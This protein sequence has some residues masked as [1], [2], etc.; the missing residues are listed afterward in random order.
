MEIAEKSDAFEE[1]LLSKALY[2][3][4]IFLTQEKKE[5][6]SE[7]GFVNIFRIKLGNRCFEGTMNEEAENTVRKYYNFCK[8]FILYDFPISNI[9]N[10]VI[11]ASLIMIRDTI[12]RLKM[13]MISFIDKKMRNLFKKLEISLDNVYFASAQKFRS[14][15]NQLMPMLYNEFEEENY[16]NK[17][18]AEI[19]LNMLEKTDD[20]SSLVRDWGSYAFQSNRIIRGI[21]Y[22]FAVTD[23]Y[24]ASEILTECFLNKIEALIFDNIITRSYKK[25]K[26]GVF[27]IV[28]K[29]KEVEINRNSINMLLKLMGKAG[30]LLIYENPKWLVV[31]ISRF[32]LWEVPE[33]IKYILWNILKGVKEFRMMEIEN[34]GVDLYRRTIEKMKQG[35]QMISEKIKELERTVQERKKSEFPLLAIE[36]H[37]TN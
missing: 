13:R 12:Y 20:I 30:V 19:F 24:V 6:V 3:S 32:W 25:T 22:Y 11:K 26:D 4:I 10:N 15:S 7:M 23:K 35:K 18:K 14:Q 9:E 34:K 27:L 31:R 8:R 28:E 2:E 21:D 16:R 36:A 33:S 29:R 5:L 17:G 1:K 37:L